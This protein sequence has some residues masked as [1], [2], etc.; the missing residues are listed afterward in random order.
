M[1]DEFA[2]VKRVLK[3]LPSVIQDKVAVKASR[4]A[5]T[6]IAKEARLRVPV[7]S[8][9]LK[10]SIGVAKAKKSDTPKGKTRFYVLPKTKVNITKKAIVNG[11]S[12]KLKLKDSAF[13]G[14]FLEF[15]T[16]HMHSRPFLLPAAKA[17]EKKAVDAFKKKV[18]TEVEKEL[19]K[20]NR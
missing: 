3:K 13:Y 8:G 12:A 18:H 15:G 10:R 5:A 9:L 14:H 11:A 7:R 6:A 16:K 20:A 4:S 2:E 1:T 19:K 17:A